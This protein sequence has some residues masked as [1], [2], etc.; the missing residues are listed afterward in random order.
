ML[1]LIHSREGTLLHEYPLE[2]G[3]Y[4]IGRRPDC[5]VHIDD[6]TVSGYHAQITVTPSE[7]MDGAFEV[8]IEDK[9]STNGTLVNGR[10]IK[11][12][13]MKHDEVARIGLHEIKLIDK[14]TR[15]F[16]ETEVILPTDN[17]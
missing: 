4:M 9:G 8:Y 15:S 16:E 5:D 11:R 6:T 12:H 1:K 3:T 2:A 13:L 14:H 10:P 7:F 17:Q